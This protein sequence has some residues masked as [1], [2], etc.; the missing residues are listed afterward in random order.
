MSTFEQYY[1]LNPIAVIDQDQWD[2]RYPDVALAFRNQAVYTPL[3]DWTSDPQKLGVTGTIVTELLEGDTNADEIPMSA[4]YIDAQGI[5]SR[6]R[7]YTVKRYGGK[8]QLHK[9]ENIFTQWQK[10]GGKDW[11]PLLRGV[12]GN[13]IV[14][15]HE[16]L[17]RNIYLSSP[18]DRWTY[19]GDATNIGALATGDKFLLDR[20]IEWNFRLGN[21]GSPVIPGDPANAKLAIVPPGVIYDLRKSMA[22]ATASEA[23]MWRDSRIYAG[24]ALNYEVGEYSGVRLI[25]APS[26]KFGINPAVLYNVGAITKQYGVTTKINAGDGAPDPELTKVDDVWY[27]GQK[28][29][30][31]YIQLEDYAENDFV[32]NDWVTIHTRRT[33]VYGVT[34]GVDPADGTAIVRR[35]YE[36]DFTNNRL[37]FDRP[38]MANYHVP[39]TGKSVTGNTD[40]TF[41]AWVTKGVSVAMCLVLGSRGG[42]LGAT[43]QPLA[44]YEPRPIDDFDSVWRF[45]YD[46]ILGHNIWEPNLFELHFCTVSLPKPGGV[47]AG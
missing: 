35:V 31:H 24:Q 10:T 38:I 7:T 3:V 5:D 36:A 42:I 45:S 28:N 40:G 11:R 37:K 4:M 6:A 19:G 22:A 17:S 12:L 26:D 9:H 15:K 18:K 23:Q 41:Y 39:M 43:A 33:N 44:F 30:T 2:Y 32:K 47:I 13:D 25:S 14:R 8:V 27:V 21:T 16:I 29:V 34:S 1:D 20:I 46:T